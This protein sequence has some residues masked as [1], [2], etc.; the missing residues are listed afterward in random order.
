MTAFRE[1]GSGRI[2]YVE[3]ECLAATGKVPNEAHD[4]GGKVRSRNYMV[5]MFF[6]GDMD[7]TTDRADP[8]AFEYVT[9]MMAFP[10]KHSSGYTN[11]PLCGSMGRI[12]VD[13]DG[14]VPF[15]SETLI[16]IVR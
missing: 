16:P 14:K 4:L 2:F 15:Y 11:C 5:T 3:H 1:G 6:A 9:D 12:K 7:E 10:D 8:E 13:K